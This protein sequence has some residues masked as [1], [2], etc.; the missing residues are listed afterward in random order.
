MDITYACTAYLT[1]QWSIIR[2]LSK[3]HTDL[4][5]TETSPPLC[6]GVYTNSDKRSTAIQQRK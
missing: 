4:A 1:A 3:M 2:K 5:G 6:Q